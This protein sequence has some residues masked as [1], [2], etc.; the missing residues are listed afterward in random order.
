[1][2][3]GAGWQ[4]AVAY[5]NIASY[6]LI[7]L[8]IGIYMGFKLDWGLEG[9]WGGIQIGIGLQTIILLIMA[10]RTDWDNEIELSKERISDAV[11]SDEEDK[12]FH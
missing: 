4:G 9:L 7:G 1:M 6:Y 12:S 11:G 10:W 8:P 3:V 2:A 5:V